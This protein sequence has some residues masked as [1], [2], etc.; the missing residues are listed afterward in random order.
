[1]IRR[2]KKK[3]R[4]GKNE[5]YYKILGVDQNAS[6][7][8]INKAYR[9]LTRIHHPDKKHPGFIE[10]KFQE[11]ND[12][13][14]VLSDIDKRTNY[15]L[16]INKTQDA[17]VIGTKKENQNSKNKTTTNSAD[18]VA[19]KQNGNSADIVATKQ[20]GNSAGIVTTNQ[21]GKRADNVTTKRDDKIAGIVTTQDSNKK[22]GECPATNKAIFDAFVNDLHESYFKPGDNKPEP[23]PNY[24]IHKKHHI[25]IE[26]YPSS[27]STEENPIHFYSKLTDNIT[28]G[29]WWERF[30]VDSW[31][32]DDMFDL[33]NIQ[34]YS[35]DPYNGDKDADQKR[36]FCNKYDFDNNP[37]DDEDDDEDDD[38]IEKQKEIEKCKKYKKYKKYKQFSK[39]KDNTIKDFVYEDNFEIHKIVNPLKKNANPSKK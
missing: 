3:R 25:K 16:T 38:E 32:I 33:V 39:I 29:N 11:I 23:D 37:E 8:K 36:D 28:Y 13:N 15:D 1:M 4:G 34:Q 26:S 12:A 22:I 6:Q 10:G 35:H 9:A 24:A 21:N 5:N 7:E 31:A 17:D 18:I 2:T 20:N 27:F 30:I 19:T 14:E